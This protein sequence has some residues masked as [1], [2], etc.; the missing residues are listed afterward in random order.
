MD[1]QK[2]VLNHVIAHTDSAAFKDH[3]N[4]TVEK[5]VNDLVTDMFRYGPVRN[6]VEKALQERVNIDLNQIDFAPINQI[7]TDMVKEK[8]AAAFS[9][10][11]REKLGK[12]LNDM[13]APAPKEITLQA[14]V[15]IFREELRDECGC[16]DPEEEMGKRNGAGH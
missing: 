12:E 8:T 4:T 10:P 5:C 3:I 7:I 11:L 15:D 14:I 1:I 2:E 6:K 9:E 16:A 13:F